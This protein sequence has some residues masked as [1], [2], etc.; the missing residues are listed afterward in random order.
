MASRPLPVSRVARR[1]RSCVLLIALTAAAA[2]A[3][4]R[5]DARYRELRDAASRGEPRPPLREDALAFAG[6]PVLERGPLVGEVLRRNPS[7]AAARSAVREALARVPQETSLA[8]PMLGYAV[9]PRS[10]G[11]SAVD[12]A[13]RVELSQ[14]LS[15]PGKRRL[16]GESALAEAEATDGDAAALRLELALQASLLFDDYWAA[17]RALEVNA[18]HRALLEELRA[19][20]LARYEAG[21]ASA[22]DPLQAETELA[23]L[24]HA[25]VELGTK[26]RLA[27]QRMNAL[28]HRDPDAELPPAPAGLEPRAPVA[29]AEAHLA[30]ALGERPE[31]RAAEQRVA[32]REAALALAEREFL[33]DFALVGGWDGFWQEKELQSFVGLEVSVPLR[34]ARRRAAVEEAKAALSRARSERDQAEDQIRLAVRSAAVRLA[35]AHHLLGIVQDRRIPAARDRVAAAR[36]GFESGLDGFLEVIEAERSL[37][38]AELALEDARADVSRRLAELEATAGRMPGLAEGGRP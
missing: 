23:E 26:V 36:A 15:W 4:P 3:G 14:A 9:G 27:R 2:C 13:H 10:F 20:A 38:D 34:L 16:R 18:E 8:D 6:A 7:L 24:L 1:R 12:D 5:L 19:I 37:L 25:E 33:P 31:L 22:Q 35:E 21:R 29:D 30:A 11:T 17:A 28:L 32:A